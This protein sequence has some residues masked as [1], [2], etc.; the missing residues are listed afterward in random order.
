[1]YQQRQRCKLCHSVHQFVMSKIFNSLTVVFKTSIIYWWKLAGRNW[2]C[3]CMPNQ[4][5]RIIPCTTKSKSNTSNTK[6]RQLHISIRKM[7]C[8]FP[9]ILLISIPFQITC[10]NRIKHKTPETVDFGLMHLRKKHKRWSF[11]KLSDFQLKQCL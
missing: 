11:D 5:L 3:S 6:V 4:K 10:F 2:Y 8:F 7:F 1:M 9:A